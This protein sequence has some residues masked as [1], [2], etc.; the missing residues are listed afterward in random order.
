MRPK[1][2]WEVMKCGKELGGQN[3][4]EGVCCLANEPGRYSGTNTG[5]FRG[6]FCWAVV[7]TLCE[8][9]VRGSFGNKSGDCLQ[10]NFFKQ[11]KEEGGIHFRMSPGY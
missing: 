1:N 4:E 3:V 5:L 7:G 8:D 11:V 9:K 2:C 6:R 10:C